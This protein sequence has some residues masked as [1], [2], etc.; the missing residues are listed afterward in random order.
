MKEGD[1]HVN[2]FAAS[3][4]ATM[5]DVLQLIGDDDGLSVQRRRNICSSIRTFARWLNRD[6]TSMPAHPG[7]YRGMIKRL[8][9]EQCGVS[10]KR[11]QNVKSDVLFSIRRLGLGGDGRTYLAPLSEKWQ[12]LSDATDDRQIKYRLSRFMRY[13]SK[14]GIS[15]EEVTDG[16]ASDFLT[17]LTEESFVKF[18][19]KIHSRVWRH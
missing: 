6:L 7:Y 12:R 9:P 10:M 15:P 13:C 19:Q 16:V 1:I 3:G 14:A 8:H 2:P 17:A 4:H 11:I 5:A 18:P